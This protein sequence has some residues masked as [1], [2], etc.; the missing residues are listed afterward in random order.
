VARDYEQI[1]RVLEAAFT[2]NDFD[3]YDVRCRLFAGEFNPHSGLES[4]AQLRRGELSFHWV[5]SGRTI[6][7]DSVAVW[8]LTLD[9]VS[10]SSRR[11]G[12]LRVHRI[13]SQRDLQ[14]DIN[15]LTSTFPVVLADALDRAL[16][17]AV[18]RLPH[19]TEGDGFIAAQAG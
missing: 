10:S 13:Y 14:V 8:T 12:A 7:L 9:L 11:R 15:L 4:G 19:P 6:S 2:S 3:G 1:Q 17:S 18:Q 16:Q 5:K